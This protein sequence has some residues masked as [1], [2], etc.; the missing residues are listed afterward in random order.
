MFSDVIERLRVEAQKTTATNAELLAEWHSELAATDE[1]VEQLP[2][3]LSKAGITTFLAGM[4][5]IAATAESYHAVVIGTA[6]FA[7]RAIIGLGSVVAGVNTIPVAGLIAFGAAVVGVVALAT[8]QVM[9]A[10]N[11]GISRDD[12]ALLEIN[13]RCDAGGRDGKIGLMNWVDGAKSVATTMIRER[14]GGGSALDVVRVGDYNGKVINIVDGVATQKV[15]R[16]PDRVV[17]HDM[18]NL[19]RNVAIGDVVDINYRGGVGVV[20]GRAMSEVGR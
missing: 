17:R 13:A 2:D 11:K 20:G 5:G 18:S 4:A 3:N 6:V 19:S 10:M 16:D 8:G 9:A 15:G 14:F 1:A 12:E 7:E